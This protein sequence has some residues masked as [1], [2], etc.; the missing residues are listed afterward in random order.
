M[1][2]S[3]DFPPVLP[4]RYEQ[5][6]THARF[7]Y[8]GRDPKPQIMSSHSNVSWPIELCE[9]PALAMITV[10]CYYCMLYC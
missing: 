6:G 1:S 7:A 8:A 9:G 4:S 10:S 3:G 2:I 5:T